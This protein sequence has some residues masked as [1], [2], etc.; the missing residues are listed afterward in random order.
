M[1]ELLNEAATLALSGLSRST[2]HRY[3]VANKF[4]SPLKPDGWHLVWVKSDVEEWLLARAILQ[5]A[6]GLNAQ[7]VLDLVALARSVDPI[8]AGRLFPRTSD[9]LRR[10]A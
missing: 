3:V 1:S 9:V 6:I 10:A 5:D 8:L 7:P 4:P 2:L